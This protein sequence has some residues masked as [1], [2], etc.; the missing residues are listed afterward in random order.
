MV[1]TFQGRSAPIASAT[2]MRKLL[3]LIFVVVASASTTW[4]Q[5]PLTP[6]NLPVEINSTG[7]TTY[8]NGIAT[9]RDNV[10][11]HVGD[12][13]IYADHAKYNSATHDVEV[14]GNVRIYRATHLYV[15]ESGIYNIDT[16]EIRATNM[17]ADY[18]PYFVAGKEISVL[19]DN[20]TIVKQGTFTTD[21]SSDPTFHLRAN[22]V[23]IYE[24]DR[25]IFQNVAFYIGK[26]PIFWWPYLYQSLNDSFSFSISPSF[27][28]SWGPSLLTEVTFPITKEIHGRVRLDYRTRRGVALGFE[29]DVNYG[30]DKESFARLK[31]YF[32]QDQNPELNR[33]NLPRGSIPTSRYR[34]TFQ[35]RTYFTKDHDL[36]TTINITKLS[37][38]FVLQDFYQSEFRYDPQPD[39]VIAATK[40]NPFYTLT[41]IGRF[42]ANSF[43]DT[44][45]RLP[46]LALDIKR[47]GLFGGPIFYE[48]E[49]SIA[50]LNRNFARNSNFQD[51]SALRADTFHQLLYPNT[52]FGWLSIV[53]RAG[54]RA[55]YYD[56]TRDLSKTIFTPNPDPL[57]PDFLLP[58]PTLKAPLQKGG[59]TVRTVFDTGVEASFKLS[60]AWEG[61]QSR[62]LG[63]DGLRHIIQPF[64]NFSYVSDTNPDPASILQF[65]RYQPST[66]LRP[67]DFPQFTSIDSIDDWSIW[68]VGVRNRLQTRRDDLTV[69]WFELE[70]YIDVNFNNPFDKT[71]YSN[72]FNRM[73]FT[74]L[75]WAT[76]SIDSQVPAFDKGFTEVNTAVILQ[77]ISKVQISL[78]HRYLDNNPFFLNSSL[79]TF[80]GYYRINDNWGVGV[81]EQYEADTGILESQRYSVYRDLTSWVASFGA[82]IRDNAGVKE[83]GVLLTFT[84][85]AFP[86]LGLDLNFDPGGAGD[87]TP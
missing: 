72:L 80:G 39:N 83:Y 67:I 60:R 73:R 63:L 46:E 4:A 38:A 10:A 65:D 20:E 9:A 19:S 14:D 85:K 51:Y 49:T 53:P 5:T 22:T 59:D 69:S 76:L 78:G 3:S 79:F 27:L 44:T 40:T 33:T 70:T 21:D 8:E 7:E 41:A 74:P 47:H 75:P 58:D 45:E 2:A 71:Q 68:R 29:S 1:L 86:K 82:V 42:Q 31:T 56:E 57:I 52:Y 18:A 61:V 36:Y 6:G 34:V 28:S 81:A 43:F 54:F 62:A 16:K 17:R 30:K 66:Q 24:G 84:L 11:I 77:P 35:D 50:D 48:G 37:D 64:T 15:G 23:R 25:V 13:D 12:T 87:T 55:T 32:L 26:V